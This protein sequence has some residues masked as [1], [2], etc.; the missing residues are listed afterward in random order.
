MSQQI[1]FRLLLEMERVMK[2]EG[3]GAGVRAPAPRAEH[4]HTSR[5]DARPRGE[6]GIK[7]PTAES[8]PPLRR[9][10]TAHRL[11]SR[12]PFPPWGN[13]NPALVPESSDSAA[14]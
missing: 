9:L 3:R 14:A 11:P 8:E 6:D 2:K 13:R 7:R 1:D 12:P 4:T 5:E 10:R